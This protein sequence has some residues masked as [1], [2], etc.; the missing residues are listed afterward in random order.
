MTAGA[1]PSRR[2]LLAALA[3][4]GAAGLWRPA[5]G[6]SGPRLAAIDW[7]MLE[8]AVAIGHMPVAA[9]ELIRYR[10][11]AVEPELPDSVVDLGLRGAPNMELLQLLRPDLILSSPYYTEI[12]PRLEAI[13]PVLAL[14][15]YLPSEPPLPRTVAALHILADAVGDPGAGLRA[16]AAA[17]AAFVREAARVAGFAERPFLVAEIGDARHVRVFG[18]GDSLFGDVLTRIGLRN[19]WTER[20]RFAFSAPV[21]LESLAAYPD[22]WLV[23]VAGIPIA[24]RHGIDRSVLWSRLGPVAE[25]RLIELP[26][27]Y[28]FG[29]IPAALRFARLLA[30]ALAPRA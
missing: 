17:E 3:F 15:F 5:R 26:S 21:P 6:A 14:P 1:R 11:D 18:D 4:A 23:I 2:D 8:T 30:D 19:A 12:L 9:C 29:G 7:A 16:E 22:A 25:G 24:A 10:E 13:A 20:T 27:V 28:G